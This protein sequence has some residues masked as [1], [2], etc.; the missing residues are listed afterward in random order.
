MLNR[1]FHHRSLQNSIDPLAIYALQG[2]FNQVGVKLQGDHSTATLT[3]IEDMWKA[4]F[5]DEVFAYSYLDDSI[6]KMYH[7]EQVTG[8]L[9]KVFAV[10]SII[11]CAIGILG[12]SVFTAVQRTREIGVRKVLGAS[13]ISIITM[14]CRQYLV[15]ITAAF[16]V[17]IPLSYTVME[18]WL[19]GFAFHISLGWS[20]FVFPVI[21]I[22]VMTLLLVGGQ[23]LKTALTNPSESLKHE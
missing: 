7:I 19:G 5:P 16:L 2:V 21:L 4:S 10:V 6:S 3:K 18:D 22:V 17:A 20:V 13:T 9:M 8:K 1:D 11:I 14:L 12:L 15:L 23:S